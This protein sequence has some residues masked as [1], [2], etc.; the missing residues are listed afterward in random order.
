MIPFSAGVIFLGFAFLFLFRAKK[1]PVFL[2]CAALFSGYGIE[3]VISGLGNNLQGLESFVD[4]LCFIVGVAL[5]P[6]GSFLII[7]TL[8]RGKRDHVLLLGL[9]VASVLIC[10]VGIISI[11]SGGNPDFYYTLAYGIVFVSFCVVTIVEA[12]ELRP[13]R[14]LPRQ[15]KVFFY[16]QRLRS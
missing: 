16:L 6:T 4:L 9:G 3:L 7:E 2:L 11:V 10:V 5:A 13:L 12:R 15:I 8:G 14:R 1:D